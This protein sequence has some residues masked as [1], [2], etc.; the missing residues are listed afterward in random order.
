M[1]FGHPK[2][3]NK[4]IFQVSY[5]FLYNNKKTMLDGLSVR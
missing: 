5:Q 1:N 4:R 2:N 3:E